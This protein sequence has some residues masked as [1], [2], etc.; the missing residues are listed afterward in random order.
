M[1]VDIKTLENGD[2]FIEFPDELI[3]DLGWQGGDILRWDKSIDGSLIMKKVNSLGVSQALIDRMV[4][5]GWSKEQVDAIL[6]VGTEIKEAY[7]KE[8]YT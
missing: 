4:A 2:K 5:V 1:K 8:R 6:E 3:A 7:V